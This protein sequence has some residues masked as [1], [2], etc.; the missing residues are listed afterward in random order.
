[1]PVSFATTGSGSETAVRPESSLTVLSRNHSPSKCTSW[2]AY[3]DEDG[4]VGMISPVPC[5]WKGPN[6]ESPTIE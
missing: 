5:M 3:Q 4:A 6:G 1:M 2:L